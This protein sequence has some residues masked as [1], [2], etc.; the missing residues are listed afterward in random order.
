MK[1]GIF[2]TDGGNNRPESHHTF[3]NPWDFVAIPCRSGAVRETRGS[4]GRFF[5]MP[6]PGQKE[7]D[8]MNQNQGD[9][10]QQRQPDQ[11]KQAG[12]QQREQQQQQ[13]GS[14][15]PGEKGDSDRKRQQD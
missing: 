2:V 3:V 5:F 12:N 4:C 8:V 11:G 7:E 15:Q 14:R 10:N 13:G 6:P 9:R 1:S